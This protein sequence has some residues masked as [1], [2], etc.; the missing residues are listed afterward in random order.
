[1]SRR[2]ERWLPMILGVLAG[3]GCY[4]AIRGGYQVPEAI[5]ELLSGAMALSAIIAGFLA[6]TKSILFS[7]PDSR[8]LKELQKLGLMEHL[9]SCLM[10]SIRWSLGLALLSA[11]SL[12]AQGSEWLR[13]LLVP[14]ATAA[15][16]SIVSYHVVASMLASLLRS[17]FRQLEDD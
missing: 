3:A 7:I 9:I 13:Y 17:R 16:T 5:G 6:T 2:S 4:G 11:A 1:M 12:L 15:V 10:S 8:R 14:W